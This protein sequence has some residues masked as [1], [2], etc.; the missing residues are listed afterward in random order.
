[1]DPLGYVG[2]IVID[3]INKYSQGQVSLTSELDVFSGMEEDMLKCLGLIIIHFVNE[4]SNNIFGRLVGNKITGPAASFLMSVFNFAHINFY[5]VEYKELFK[6]V[7]RG[8]FQRI[9]PDDVYEVLDEMDAK[10]FSNCVLEGVELALIDLGLK[11]PQKMELPLKGIVT[12]P[13]NYLLKIPNKIY[14]EVSGSV[15]N[16][17]GD[18]LE[19]ELR[20]LPKEN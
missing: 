14:T 6:N 17:L 10:T 7:L 4:R 3:G 20:Q 16:I 11:P 1:M 12:T 13:I 2:A 15:K 18:I 19:N 5:P 8:M 9:L